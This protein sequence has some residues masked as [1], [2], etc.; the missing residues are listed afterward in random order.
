MET[1]FL[2]CG[3]GGPQLKRNPLGSAHR[4]PMRSAA[5]LACLA[6]CTSQSAQYSPSKADR[7]L[8]STLT[9]PESV[10]QTIVLAAEGPVAPIRSLDS[11][12]ALAS[13]VGLEFGLDSGRVRVALST[14]RERLGPD[15][16]VFESERGYG[17]APDSIGIL[18]SRD[19]MSI[20]RA[21]STSG[22]NYDIDTDSII[23]LVR[24]WHHN[25]AFRLNAAGGDWLEGSI[26]PSSTA[27]KALAQEVYAA[28]PD[29]VE[30]GTNTVEGLEAEM[31]RTKL[32]FC[33][34]D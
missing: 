19:T 4:R 2:A 29:V 15:Y 1:I 6:T 7:D 5:L 12:G 16:L 9:Y 22:V 26:S 21:M 23:S 27:W 18:R 17:Y 28:C 25:Y 31:R 13:L 30:Q 34:W 10:L 32:L 20:L 3:A 11:S 8:A 33:W 14:L 24:Q